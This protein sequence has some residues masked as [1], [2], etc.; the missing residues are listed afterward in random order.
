MDILAVL[1]LAA[2][3]LVP[4]PPSRPAPPPPPPMPEFKSPPVCEAYWNRHFASWNADERVW[5]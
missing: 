3:S 1:M 4:P 2:Q 5:S